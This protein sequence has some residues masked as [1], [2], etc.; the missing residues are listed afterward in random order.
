[1]VFCMVPT[2]VLVH[3]YS[4]DK[5]IPFGGIGYGFFFFGDWIGKK[6]LRNGI[7]PTT[8]LYRGAYEK[9]A[10]YLC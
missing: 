3:R 1:M 8:W 9:I 6:L 4:V 5:R 10:L 2:S 7:G